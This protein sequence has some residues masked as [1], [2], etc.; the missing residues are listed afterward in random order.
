VPGIPSETT[1][2]EQVLAALRQMIGDSSLSPTDDFYLAGGHSLLIMRIVRCLRDEHGI[3]LDVRS[4]GVNSQVAALMAVARP[5]PGWA[6][7][8]RA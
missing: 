4:F 7:G 6:A 3:D 2:G 5:L 1:A 8:E